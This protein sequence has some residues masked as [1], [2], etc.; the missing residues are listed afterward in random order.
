[1]G[2]KSKGG[3]D[4]HFFRPR[5]RGRITSEDHATSRLNDGG[6]ARHLPVGKFPQAP[7]PGEYDGSASL[8]SRLACSTKAM[9]ITRRLP[10]GS[11]ILS[12]SVLWRSHDFSSRWVHSRF[13][14]L[15]RLMSDCFQDC[16]RYEIMN[17][18]KSDEDT[19]HRHYFLVIR[20]STL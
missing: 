20:Q 1:M 6:F 9:F 10:V 18:G 19:R 5:G 15:W 8:F 4:A 12:H 3:G 2:R 14:S 11:Y 13:G 17:E 7:K 16:P